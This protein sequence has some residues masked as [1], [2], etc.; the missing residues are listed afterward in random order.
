MAIFMKKFN[1]NFREKN[2]GKFNENFGE[3][4]R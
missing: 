4:L 2:Q 1:E 3:K